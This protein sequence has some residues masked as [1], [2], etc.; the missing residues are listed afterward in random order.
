LA[1]KN[2]HLLSLLQ[3]RLG[4]VETE[5]EPEA[6]IDSRVPHCPVCGKPMILVEIVPPGGFDLRNN[7]PQPAK[8]TARPP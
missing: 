2:N 5:P 6:K 4:T 8:L 7:V 1:A 3:Y